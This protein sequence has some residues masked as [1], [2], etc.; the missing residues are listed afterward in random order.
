MEPM[1][2]VYLILLLIS[3]ALSMLLQPKPPKGPSPE[4][5]SDVPTA[6]PARYVPVLFGTRTFKS[7]NVIWYGDV[8]ADPKRTKGG[9]K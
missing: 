9:K 2:I 6:D 8:K 4:E 3:V 7:M 1:T 5:M